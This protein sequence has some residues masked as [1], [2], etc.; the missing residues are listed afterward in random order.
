[1]RSN[2]AT[3]WDF[4]QVTRNRMLNIEQGKG[5]PAQTFHT[6]NHT[7]KGLRQGG[8]FCLYK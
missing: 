2:I 8:S 4:K 1:M 3:L 5:V 6:Y 7:T